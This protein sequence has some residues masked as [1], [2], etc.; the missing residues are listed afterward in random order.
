[1]TSLP[2]TDA[3][4]LTRA[5]LPGGQRRCPVVRPHLLA[6]AVAMASLGGAMGLVDADELPNSPRFAAF[7][8]DF[9][10]NGSGQGEAVD[11][12]RFSR[13]TVL[14]AGTYRLDILL[15]ERWI[16]RQEVRLQDDKDAPNGARVCFTPT[17]LGTIGLDLDK[18]PDPAAARAKLESEECLD[19]TQLVPS[20]SVNVDLSELSAYLSVPQAYLGRQVRGE[21]DPRD[22]D[23]GV[24]AGFIGYSA[25]LYRNHTDSGDTQQ[26]SIG[27]NNGI[28]LGDWRLRTNGNYNRSS[29]SG[30]P[31]RSHYSNSSTYVQ[32]DLTGIRSQLTVGDYYTPGEL[33]DSVPFRGVQVSSDDRMLPDALRG[34][35]PVIRGVAETNAK[36]TIRQ[37]ASILHEVTVSPGPFSIED[38]YDSGYSGDL[39]V[40]VTEADGRQR[41]FLVPYA[42]VAQLLR[43][44]MSRFSVTAGEYRND[45]AERVPRF[46][47]GT[48]QRGI[49]NDWSAYTGSIIAEKYMAVQGGVALST[50]LGAL[51]L[52]V[53]QS[54]VKESP[55]R[56]EDSTPKGGR[57]YRMTY[58]KLVDATQT[59][60]TMAAY[61]FSSR[62]YLSFSDYAQ[63][64]GNPQGGLYRQRSRFQVSATQPLPGEMGSLYLSG[65]SQKYWDASR[66]G[67]MTFQGGYSNSYRWG[68]MSLSVGRT[69]MGE[70]Y[71]NQYMM[72]FNIPIGDVGRSASL[73][74]SVNYAKGRSSTQASLSGS[75]GEQ[76][77]ASYSLYGST[78]RDQGERFNNTG[79]SFNYR[80]SAVALNAG[81]SKGTGYRQEN[82]GATGT[83]VLHPGG[84][85]FTQTQGETLAII[86]AKGAQGAYVS[87]DAGARIAGNGYAV[88]G[89]LSPYRQNQVVIDPAG[90][91]RNVELQVTEQSVAPRHGAVVMLNYPTISGIPV[92][93][94]IVRDNG[95]NPPLGSEVLD[96][97]GK[98]LAM[99]GQAG[100]AFLRGLD[101]TGSL[102][103]RWGSDPDK[104]CTFEYRLPEADPDDLNYQQ[105]EVRC[106]TRTGRS[107]V[108]FAD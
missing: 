99:V 25:N 76:S 93:L 92:L 3:V 70:G 59:N 10:F 83:I 30:A 64:Y 31:S 87:N 46:V 96:A 65:S 26:L 36:V 98:S 68:S 56:T 81:L 71:E 101:P 52:D 32:R 102:V 66:K 12:S 35:A 15:N 53:T 103:V 18:L 27:L 9:L 33:F 8:P 95:E 42:S 39:E 23:R 72:S 14:P 97:D 37:G 107:E 49:S 5:L 91:F 21:V 6:F 34:Y 47:Q 2:D 19:L 67:D 63:A 100:R 41:T 4:G 82:L 58:S 84:V 85:N 86:E 78:S 90:L 62:G 48:Y 17:Q 94:K 69:R 74:T 38:L 11:L 40:T 50:G 24:T 89:G 105:L 22:W 29:S 16:G 43:P 106:I 75:L 20:S 61:R 1:M 55:L 73:S 28:N 88:V 77:Q 54:Q 108:A 60:F 44:G 80:A 79:G 45:S 7:N 57:S 51:A 104:R 13:G